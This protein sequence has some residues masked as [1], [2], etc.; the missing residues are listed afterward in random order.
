[1]RAVPALLAAAAFGLIVRALRRRAWELRRAIEIM[2][3]Q[4]RRLVAE[5][6]LTGTVDIDTGDELLRMRPSAYVNRD[7]WGDE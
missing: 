7:D 5:L 6:L 2:D 1:M 3:E 4:H